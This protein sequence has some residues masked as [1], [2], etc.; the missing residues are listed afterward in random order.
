MGI[1]IQ[2]AQFILSLS[3]LIVLHE[4]GHFLAAK[5]FKTRVEK[6]YLFFNPWFSLFRK[7]IG[8]TEYG[9]GWL[10]LGGYVKISGMIDESMDKKQ[11]MSEPQPFEFRSKPAWQRLIIMIGGVTVNAILGILIFAMVL[12]VWGERYLPNENAI[13]GINVDSVGQTIGLQD[14]DKIISIDGQKLDRFEQFTY[15]FI[16]NEA[17]NIKVFRDGDTVDINV[18]KGTIGKITKSKVRTLAEPR[19]PVQ[20]AKLQKGSAAEEAGLE[21]E[22]R[23]IAVNDEPV[24][25]Y[26]EFEDVKQ[27]NKDKEI[28]LTVIKENNDTVALTAHVPEN[29][30]LGFMPYYYDNFLEM[31]RIEYGFFEAIPAGLDKAVATFTDYVKQIKLIF[32]SD[33]IKASESVGGFIS[34]GS[35]FSTSWDW[36][37][38]W[39]MTAWL[40]I[41]LAFMNLLPIPALDGG[42]VMFL[43]WEIVTGRQPNQKVLEYAQVAGMILLFG[44]LIFANANDVI[45]LFK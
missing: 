23:I 6:F 1:L 13:Y 34:I 4:G 28:T 17:N 10:P 30:T 21:K 36:H 44:L 26:D 8:E 18:P 38:F 12:F 3:I 2:A 37:R 25:F 5:A 9:I 7:K 20:V 15:Q 11:M 45:R 24:R 19:F 39:V 31:D 29:G 42:H 41:I 22:D 32:T 16:I 43:L 35:I 27:L 40:S 33:E 14:G